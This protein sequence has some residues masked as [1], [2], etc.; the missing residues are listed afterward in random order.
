MG[1]LP[2]FFPDSDVLEHNLLRFLCGT[3]DRYIVTVIKIRGLRTNSVRSRQD[4]P[5]GDFMSAKPKTV[6]VAG[7]QEVIFHTEF[8]NI[9]S[10]IRA[11]R[12]GFHDCIDAEDMF[13]EFFGKPR[14]TKIIPPRSCGRRAPHGGLSASGTIEYTF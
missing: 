1:C 4:S 7:S 12:A 5:S 8:D 11:R 9:T 2:S 10:T 14:A 6:I 13:T 3:D